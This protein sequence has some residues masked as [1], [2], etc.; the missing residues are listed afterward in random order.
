[1]THFLRHTTL[2]FGMVFV[3]LLVAMPTYA[4]PSEPEESTLFQP[5][6]TLNSMAIYPE[7]LSGRTA[8]R[9]SA[10]AD[11]PNFQ[12][13]SSMDGPG[14]FITQIFARSTAC[15]PSYGNG[16]RAVVDAVPGQV[17]T[18]YGWAGEQLLSDE[19]FRQRAERYTVTVTALGQI[20]V[21]QHYVTVPTIDI[22]EPSDWATVQGTITVRGWAIDAASWNGSGVDQ[23]QIHSGGRLLGN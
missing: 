2:L 22:N 3:L 6:S 12:L 4:D 13:R 8:I 14:G 18:V 10:C 16:W 1:M 17:F 9:I 19:A 11:V 15:P 5:E 20:N 7:V 21:Q 23:V